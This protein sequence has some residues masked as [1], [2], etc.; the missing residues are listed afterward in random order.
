MES[1]KQKQIAERFRVTC[2]LFEAGCEIMRQNLKRRHP[3]LGTAEL[4][5]RFIEWLRDR[6]GAEHGDA[7]GILVA[8]PRSKSRARSTRQWLP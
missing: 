5:V 6:P 7:P 3:D 8:W 4:H 1:S 2:E